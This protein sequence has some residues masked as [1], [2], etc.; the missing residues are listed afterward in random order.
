MTFLYCL[1]LGAASAIPKL[2]FDAFLSPPPPPVECA[3]DMADY[4]VRL[5]PWDEP[6]TFLYLA[7]GEFH[8]VEMQPGYLVS[9]CELV[10]ITNRTIE[11]NRLEAELTALKT[12]R[13]KE[14]QL[15][16]VIESQYV[17]Q[18]NAVA[19]PS[20]WQRHQM[21]IG[22]AVGVVATSLTLVT[23]AQLLD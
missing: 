20:W 1:V 22:I 5:L 11:A 3:A 19:M 17:R 16:R 7:D 18:L 4:P 23:A 15:W 14:F 2:D 13:D 8:D 9:A 21:A 6:Q 10:R 12:L